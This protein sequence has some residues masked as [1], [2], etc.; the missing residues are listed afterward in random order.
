MNRYAVS[1][2]NFKHDSQ[3]VQLSA[4]M[5]ANSLGSFLRGPFFAMPVTYFDLFLF[6]LL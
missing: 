1:F 3:P 6:Q 2:L 5:T 4:F